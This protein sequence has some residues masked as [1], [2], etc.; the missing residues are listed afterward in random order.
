LRP[1]EDG[2][3]IVEG[4]TYK[5]EVSSKKVFQDLSSTH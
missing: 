5:V 2:E 3:K 4:E 1:E